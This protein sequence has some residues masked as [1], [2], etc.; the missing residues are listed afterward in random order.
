LT[1]LPAINHIRATCAIS[2]NR[3]RR[4]GKTLFEMKG[5]LAKDFLDAAYEFASLKYP[6]FYKMDNL[7]KLGL[8]AADILLRESDLLG[9][10]SPESIGI[11]LSNAN[12]SLDTD[13]KYYKTVSEFASPAL[14]VYTLPNIMIGEIS[15]RYN[16]KGE[17]AFFIS[18][19]F[20]VSFMSDYVDNLINNNIL[21][22]CIC[23]WVEL[24]HE[25]YQAVLFLIEK[26]ANN[27][28]GSLL[29]NKENI[30]N[31]YQ[32]ENG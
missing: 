15:I 14:F 3:I 25:T 11:V 10:Y 1:V 31:L 5:I 13:I 27:A 26:P 18:R 23:G 24:L 28:G 19:E 7:S 12:S 32:S 17:N 29:F 30:L 22:C 4:N 6:R 2:Q 9:N 16:I 20:D 8:L 21:Q